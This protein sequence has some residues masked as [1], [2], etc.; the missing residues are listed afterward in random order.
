[1]KMKMKEKAKE[2][3]KRKVTV[4]FRGGEG[5]HL[6]A[7]LRSDL[8]GAGETLIVVDGDSKG[9]LWVD[10]RKTTETLLPISFL[11]KRLHDRVSSV[12]VR[13]RGGIRP[14]DDPPQIEYGSPDEEGELPTIEEVLDRIACLESKRSC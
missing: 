12:V 3:E 11:K 13:G 8:E 14:V 10:R 4:L 9:V 6:C 7:C 2:K 1:M 5:A